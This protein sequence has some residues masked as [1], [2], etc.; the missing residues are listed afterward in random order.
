MLSLAFDIRARRAVGVF[1]K[2]LF[3]LGGMRGAYAALVLGSL[4]Q[5]VA[6][7]FQT[8]ALATCLANLWDGRGVEDQLPLFACFLTCFIGRRGVVLVQEELLDSFARRKAGDLQSR[9]LSLALD[10][11][12]GL[13]RQVG[14]AASASVA[15]EGID[16]I[17]RYVRIVPRRQCE[18]VGISGALLVALFAIDWV[19]G[20]IAAVSFPVIV[21]FMIVLGR[22]AQSRASAR[23]QESK[24][25]SNHFIDTLRGMQTIQSLDAEQRAGRSVYAASERL[26]VATVKT[27]S[28]A[29]LSSAVLDLVTVFGVAA[30]AM[31]LAFRLLDGTIAL[32]VALSTLMLAP[33]FFAPIRAFASKFHASLDGKNAL[34]AVFDIIDAHGDAQAVQPVC[35]IPRWNGDACLEARDIAFSYDG[36]HDTVKGVS[37]SCAGHAK[38]GIVGASGAGK[39]TLVDLLA[40]FTCPSDGSFFVNGE[41]VDLMSPS[42]REQIHYIPQHPYLFNMT[43]ADNIRL[44]APDA[45]REEVWQAACAAGLDRLIC[46]LE[47]GL[48]TR[49][50][51]GGR[52]LSGGEA[53]RIALA[54]A[55]LGKREVL[56]FDEPTA[57]LDIE[58]ELEL[59]TQMLAC[60]EGRLV[61]FATHRLHWIS[62]MDLVIVMEDGTVVESGTP[63]ELLSRDG[64]LKRLVER[65]RTGK[66]A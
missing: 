45:T 54:R 38:V 66:V 40:G 19:S 9:L 57:H 50:G 5:A 48:D 31:M 21:F 27:L 22:Q 37:F 11:S 4:A 14:S 25:L 61:F 12:V 15:T 65:E 33:E 26:R 53:Q 34:A 60:M 63:D 10:G 7:V 35:P 23:F 56:L 59:K 30:C 36:A 41:R 47:S 8:L 28:V 24:R 17:S 58:T 16:D 29:T 6:I 39:S 1:D 3:R 43:L 62:N 13:A 42:W 20:V 2:A 18:L 32:S 51:E 49:V 64:A 46:D 55:L 44:Y 52:G